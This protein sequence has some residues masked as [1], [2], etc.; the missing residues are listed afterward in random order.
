MARPSQGLDEALLRSGLALLPQLGCSGLSVRRVAEH[1]GVNP[2]MFHYHFESK[3]VFLRSLLQQVY[4][5]MF[6]QLAAGA[7]Q[8]GPAL[9]RLQ[10][11]LEAI[12]RFAR[13]HHALIGRLVVDAANGEQV[14]H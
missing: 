11:A 7:A 13:E 1:A 10:A 5:R 2:A 9:A 8:E 12:A 6:S 4:E 3:A 14:V